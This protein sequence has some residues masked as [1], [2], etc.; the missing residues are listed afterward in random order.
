[1]L[2]NRVPEKKPIWSRALGK[3]DL[4]LVDFPAT[5]VYNVAIPI[6]APFVFFYE[7]THED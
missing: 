6:M 4:V 7:F 2:K 1:M 3:A 5:L